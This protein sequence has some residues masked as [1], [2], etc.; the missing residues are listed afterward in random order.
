MSPSPLLH[1]HA[2]RKQFGKQ[3]TAAGVDLQVANGEFFTMLGPSGSGKST[4][5]RM[6]AG[7]EHP[8]SG[9]ILI[10]GQDVTDLPPWRRDLGMVFQQYA[11]FP[12]MTVAQNI[13][14]G[15]RRRKLD[16]EAVRKRVSELLDLVSLPGFEERPVTRLSGGE[17]Q[18]V[19]IARA[20]APRPRLLLLDEP[21][22]ALDEKIRREMQAQLKDIQRVTGT[23]FVYVTHD[24]EEA[25]TMSDRVAVLNWGHLVQVDEPHALFRHP[26][27]KFV[28]TFFRG[29]NV[30]EG[31]LVGQGRSSIFECS[32]FRVAL[33]ELPSKFAHPPAVA[34]RG[35]D[36]RINGHP[37]P[38][39]ITFDAVLERVV[40][41]GVYTDYQLRL[42]DGQVV[43]ASA[44]S[45]QNLPAGQKVQ[46]AVRPE[47]ITPLQAEPA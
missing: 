34:I 35:E 9:R 46:V 40:Y 32:A 27:T 43:T 5:L 25:L 29:S 8:D 1:V 20:L 22:S 13:A 30:V 36:L 17:Q 26:R 31:K 47:G 41:R 10:N 4:I 33:P 28:A 24:Q 44:T 3:V 6:I 18:R 45:G 19:A 39:D 14:Y 16:R 7:L 2:V 42:V 15:L 23:A 12:H 37:S 38:E 11:N 21:L